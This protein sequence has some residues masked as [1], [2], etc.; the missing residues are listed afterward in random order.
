[1]K[2]DERHRHRTK[3]RAEQETNPSIPPSFIFECRIKNGVIIPGNS[4]QSS[5]LLIPE[6]WLLWKNKKFNSVS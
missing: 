5:E 2:A 3:S 6:G 4:D 1:M